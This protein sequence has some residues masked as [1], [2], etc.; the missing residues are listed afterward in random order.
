MLIHP[1]SCSFIHASS[2]RRTLADAAAL[3][4]VASAAVPAAWPAA[5]AIYGRDE[6]SVVPILG[7]IWG[8]ASPGGVQVFDRT[9]AQLSQLARSEIQLKQL[10]LDLGDASTPSTA[11]DSAT[12]LRLSAVYFKTAPAQM[13]LCTKLMERLSAAEAEEAY[14]LADTFEAA[15]AALEQGCRTLDMKAQCDGARAARGALHRYIELAAGRYTVPQVAEAALSIRGVSRPVS[16][17]S[18]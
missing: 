12:V 3:A 2:R 10:E 18:E 5:L 17:F 9:A 8:L 11:E 14:A 15:V 16:L 13:V 6:L 7:D 1:G 4:L